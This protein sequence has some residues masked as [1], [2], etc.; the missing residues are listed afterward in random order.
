MITVFM[1]L[2]IYI[3][4]SLWC[5]WYGGSFGQRSFIDYYGLLAIPLALVL[6]QL[7]IFRKWA[8]YAMV[9]V[10]FI[11]LAFNLFQTE[12]YLKSSI[13]FADMTKAAYWN[14]FWHIRP[15]NGFYDL[16]E[17]PDYDLAKKGIY[18]VQPKN[19]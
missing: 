11:L 19:K 16:L 12:K 7:A 5:W 4:F 14:S 8:Y 15:Q 17:T 1:V 6:T 18:V 9:L 13:H 10:V 3:I 2:N